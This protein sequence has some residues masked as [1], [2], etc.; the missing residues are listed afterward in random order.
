VIVVT[1]AAGQLGSAF[2]AV[3]GSRARFWDRTDLDLSHVEDI[4][5]V[6]RAATPSLLINCAAYTAVDAAESDAETA[7][8]VNAAAV[9]EVAAACA[10]IGAGFV[11][12]STDYVFD[13]N[14]G[15][16]YVESDE[17]RPINVYGATKL[18]GERLALAAHPSPLV[19]RSSWIM[20]GTHR[21]FASTMVGLIGKGPVRV[22]DDQ[23]GSPTFADDLARATIGAIGLGGTGVLHLTNSGDATWF[24][25]ASE[26]ARLLGADPAVVT[27]CTTDEFPRPAPRPRHSVLGSERRNALGLDPLPDWHEGL[28][29]AVAALSGA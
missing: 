14:K 27:P 13:G 2:R 17:P 24:E 8:L 15:A 4:G 16:A 11:T 23:R 10:T 12:F 19:I 21:S 6:V 28:S 20:S 9:G 1:G 3:L 5:P 18:E 26:I 25:I 7:R 29:R 22:V